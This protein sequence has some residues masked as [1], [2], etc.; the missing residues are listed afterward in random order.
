[1]IMISLLLLASLLPHLTFTAH[2]NVGIVNGRLAKHRP[3]MASLQINFNHTCGGFLISDQWVLTAA[4][5]WNWPV[6]ICPQFL[7][8]VVGVLDITKSTSSNRIKVKKCIPHLESCSRTSRNDIMLLMLDKKIDLNNNVKTIDL[9]K[10]GEDVKARSVCSVMGWGTVKPNGNLSAQLLEAD[11]SIQNPAEC[12]NRWGTFYIDSQMICVRG[13]GGTCQGD[14]GGPLVCG[15]IA[16]GITSFGGIICNS[17]QA[18]NVY[19]KISAYLP[20]IKKNMRN[21]K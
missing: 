10:E 19:T 16:V 21:V 18:P 1:M 9:P 15:N 2:V 3:Y 6:E 5:C 17:P 8:V 13:R 4:H 11:V 12:R 20:W 14:S 7:T